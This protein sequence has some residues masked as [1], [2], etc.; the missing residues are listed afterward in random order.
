MPQ[1]FSP[2]RPWCRIIFVLVPLLLCGL[3]SL[4]LA[5]AAETGQGVVRLIPAIEGYPAGQ[6]TPL[7]LLVRDARAARQVGRGQQVHLGLELQAP[8]GVAVHLQ[9]VM[10]PQSIPQSIHQNIH[11]SMP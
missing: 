11:R 4:P 6:S 8:A 10:Q 3:A 7:L 2:F 5:W 9:R 1:R